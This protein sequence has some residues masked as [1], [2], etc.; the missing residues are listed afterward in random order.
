MIM[1]R[2]VTKVLLATTILTGAGS[3]YAAKTTSSFEESSAF[4]MQQDLANS[5][6]KYRN[7]I[8]D[9]DDYGSDTDS[10]FDEDFDD[11]DDYV[12]KQ[13][14]AAEPKK[15]VHATANAK[16]QK[17]V[18][19]KMNKK[20]LGAK[21]AGLSNLFGAKNRE[22]AKKKVDASAA[23]KAKANDS[24]APPKANASVPKAPSIP[25]APAA[26]KAPEAPKVKPSLGNL[27][28]L[29][30]I[31]Q[32]DKA[33]LKKVNKPVV[34]KKSINVAHKQPKKAVEVPN[35]DDWDTDDDVV[36]KKPAIKKNFSFGNSAL[37]NF[38]KPADK[39]A[40]DKKKPAKKIMEK[41]AEAKIV[42]VK[43]KAPAKKKQEIKGA[44]NF[45]KSKIAERKTEA[46][47][48]GA[49]SSIK[50]RAKAYLKNASKDSNKEKKIVSGGS[51]KDRKKAFANSGSSEI[52]DI[53][54]ELASLRAKG[55]NKSSIANKLSS[56]LEGKKANKSKKS[57]FKSKKLSKHKGNALGGLFGGG[58]S[59][60]AL[61]MMNRSRNMSKGKA[62]AKSAISNKTKISD[63]KA[64][65]AS[66][67]EKSASLQ[68]TTAKT[69]NSNSI[70]SAPKIHSDAKVVVQAK[71]APMNLLDAIRTGKA[72]KK[73]KKNKKKLVN[74]NSMIETIMAKRKAMKV[75]GLSIEEKIAQNKLDKTAQRVAEQTKLDAMTPKERKEYLSKRNNIIGKKKIKTIKNQK[76]NNVVVLSFE[77]MKAKRAAEK[78][79]KLAAM[80][81]EQIAAKSAKRK[82]IEAEL[83]REVN[84]RKAAIESKKKV[85]KQK[86]ARKLSELPKSEDEQIL[87]LLADIA[88]L[89]SQISESKTVLSEIDE[90]ILTEAVV[91]SLAT[92]EVEQVR[93]EWEKADK[94]EEKAKQEEKEEE[95]AQTE[96]KAK[97]IAEA[98]AIEVAIA[99]TVAKATENATSNT[100]NI[101]NISEEISGTVIKSIMSRLA[102]RSFAGIAAGD[103]EETTIEKGLWIS[104]LYSSAK[105]GK[106]GKNAGYTSQGNGF[107]IGFDA[108]VKEDI[109]IGFA[110]GKVMSK[111]KH[112]AKNAGTSSVNADILSLYSQATFG[113][114][115]ADVILSTIRST[116]N[117][118]HAL[119]SGKLKNSG[120]GAQASVAYKAKLSDRFTLVPNAS[121]D[122]NQY[123]SKAYKETG[124]N[125]Y[126][127]AIKAKTSSTLGVKAGVKLLMPIKKSLLTT[128]TPYLSADVRHAS[129][130]KGDKVTRIDVKYFDSSLS[131]T[132][133]NKNKSEISYN[134]GGGVIAQHNNIQ[135][136]ANYDCTLKKKYQNHQGS[137]RLRIEF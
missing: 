11:Y 13:A 72:L 12:E 53:Q 113:N 96:A 8:Q 54:K 66:L 3:A 85:T 67:K 64:K 134:V 119:G 84:T 90:E 69:L 68:K 108:E 74:P 131:E 7:F 132:V 93:R 56:M 104:G 91:A 122:Y 18:V 95:L 81:P 40:E 82:R 32:N 123:S 23:A 9:D 44:D 86:S 106:I 48:M 16:A 110:Y 102:S 33:G 37:K 111:Y 25:K 21:F 65:L 121:V 55:S 31:Q 42:V 77:E 107:T 125:N 75:S 5:L 20:N 59:A 41:K 129:K 118:K 76:G 52:S 39:K 124:A 126:S 83:A 45:L 30:Q 62:P 99:A 10:E 71:R 137:V 35:D 34:N 98:K 114:I 46:K 58:R 127:V 135:L 112:K 120:Y 89:E 92:Y 88:E 100:Q 60:K 109:K 63:L 70:P 105:Q 2:I 136:Q 29:G 80:T 24:K 1:T 115:V 103:E 17:K 43:A 116:I 26:P 73:T 49:S 28:L 51:I 78:A 57:K 36:V 87:E 22:E 117:N 4:S 15:I 50:D 97:V 133:R 79:A 38:I 128:I 61:E 47:V 14:K 27:G 6:S 101:S 94:E 130:V 19:K